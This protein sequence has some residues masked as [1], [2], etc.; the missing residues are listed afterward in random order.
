MS[1]ERAERNQVF[2]GAAPAP[3]VDPRIP[4]T[5]AADKARAD[6]GLEVLPAEI[7]PLPS[8]GVVY[9]TGSPPPHF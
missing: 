1:E 2:T 7:V 8:A 6:F 9:P 4:T 3:G 5:T